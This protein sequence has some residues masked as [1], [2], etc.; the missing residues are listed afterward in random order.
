MTEAD[1]LTACA[2][3]PDDDLTRLAFADWLEERGDAERADFIRLRVE[4]WSQELQDK[5]EWTG[6]EDRLKQHRE[7][8]TVALAVV[9]NPVWWQRFDRS[10][11]LS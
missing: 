5:K 3:N 7:R 1:F 2:D 11:K 10:R 4:L 8:W 9:A 6:A